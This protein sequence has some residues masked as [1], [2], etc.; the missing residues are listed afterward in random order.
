MKSLPLFHQLAGKPVLVLGGGDAATAKRRLVERAGGALIDE[1]EQG[2]KA[3]A[4][5]AFVAHDDPALVERDVARLKAEG[6]IVNAV[7]RPELCDFTTPSVLDR[8]PVLIAFGT[9]GASAGLAKALRL[10][11][12]RLLPGNLGELA[13]GLFSVRGV[14]RSRWPD[15]ADRRRVIDAALEEGGAL[16]PMRDS[17]AFAV[18]DWAARTA[19]AGEKAQ[20]VELEISSDDPDDLTLRH[21]RLLGAADYVVCDGLLSEGIVARCRADAV[22][23]RELP[24]PAPEAGLIVI[25]TKR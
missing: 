24:D 1:I 21:A 16:D 5:I 15:P 14:L 2:L 11:F 22:R 20:R 25:I 13:N 8:D 4:R 7:D 18:A 6:L 19:D 9:G 12:E 17:S 10:R 3:G 23:L